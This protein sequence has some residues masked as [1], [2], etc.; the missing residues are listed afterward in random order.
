MPPAER[1]R[2]HR[3]RREL[4]LRCVL[5]ELHDSEIDRLIAIGLLSSERRSDP[6]AIKAALYSVLDRSLVA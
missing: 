1:M 2:L 5:I 3:K 6:E 4:G